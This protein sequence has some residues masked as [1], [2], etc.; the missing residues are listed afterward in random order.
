MNRRELLELAPA[1]AALI[2][3]E[4]GVAPP[5][6]AQGRGPDAPMR[7][8]KDQLKN[9]LEILGLDFTDEQ[10]DLTFTVKDAL[11]PAQQ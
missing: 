4:A 5:A 6:A 11:P 8:N 2:V 3:A 1:V 9:A 10:R 7:I